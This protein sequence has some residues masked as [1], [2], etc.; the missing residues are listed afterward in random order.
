MDRCVTLAFALSVLCSAGHAQVQHGRTTG[1]ATAGSF[2]TETAAAGEAARA[3]GPVSIESHRPLRPHGQAASSG[4]ALPQGGIA[5][6]TQAA[7]LGQFHYGLVDN[8]TFFPPDPTIAV[9]PQHY[10][11]T[12]NQRLGISAKTTTF[13]TTMSLNGAGPGTGLFQSVGAGASTF[14]PKCLFDQYSGRFMVVALE[15]PSPTQ[16][17]ID[18][19][20]SDDSNPNGTWFTYRT[21]ALTTVLGQSCGVDYPG[22]GV[23]ADAI[24]VATNLFTTPVGPTATFAGVK[25]RVYQK[26]AM[27]S[28]GTAVFTDLLSTTAASVQ[29]THPYGTP[30]AAYFVSAFSPTTLQLDAITDPLGA[31]TMTTTF[32]TVPTFGF[33]VGG[34]PQLGSAVTLDVLDGRIMNA[35]WRNG[36]LYTAHGVTVGTRTL[37]RWYEIATNGF[38]A[39]TPSLVQTGDIDLG[40]GIHTWYPAISVNAADDVAVVFARSASTERPSVQVVSRSVTDPAGT[41]SSPITIS[42]APQTG[43][44]PYVDPIGGNP[45]RWGDFF[46]IAIDPADNFTFW[47]VGECLIKF[48]GFPTTPTWATAIGRFTVTPPPP[49]PVITSIT[50]NSAP[51][52]GDFLTIKGTGIQGATQVTVGPH[53]LPRQVLA[54]PQFVPFGF[55]YGFTPID[56][57]PV[58]TLFVFGYPPL[59][60]LGTENVTVTTLVGTSLPAPITVNV[61]DPPK[62]VLTPVSTL[63]GNPMTVAWGGTPGQMALLATSLTFNTAIVN[64][65]ETLLPDALIPLPDLAGAGAASFTVQTPVLPTLPANIYLQLWTVAPPGTDP[66]TFEPSPIRV[67]ILN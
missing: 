21:N 12:V 45:S 36:R 26:A 13:S 20:I 43:Q 67:A 32:V 59:Q 46:G 38:P 50:P 54:N 41:M 18:I 30:S 62:V 11:E 63:A 28:G 57:Q 55:N 47:G 7:T 25:Y 66:L 29:A 22:F 2:S 52:V 5:S 60:N 6:G 9:G 53:V 34:A 61:T 15:N 10:I 3:A 8:F 17:F 56:F 19:A 40:A 51:A 58:D 48:V 42:P 44:V 23:D 27:L 14:D 37:A 31:V 4:Q 65:F 33:P 24:Y 16:S 49:F 39:G 64:G 1:T 35:D